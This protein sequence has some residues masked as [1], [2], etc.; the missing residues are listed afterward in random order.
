MPSQRRV[1]LGFHIGHDRSAALVMDGRVVAMVAEERLDRRKY[2]ASDTI[3]MK[4]VRYVLALAGVRAD[5]VTDIAFTHGG[6][7]VS[8]RIE[9]NWRKEILA[10]LDLP[11]RPVTMLGHHFAHACAAF[12]TSPS[13]EAAIAVADG[14][15]DI[16]DDEQCE[17]E[18]FYTADEEGITLVANRFQNNTIKYGTALA[19]ERF[20]YMPPSIRDCQISIGRKYQQVTQMLGFRFGQAGKTMGLA[21]YVSPTR[22]PRH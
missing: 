5:V 18:S 17:A 13:R 22:L 9:E 14:A 10:A 12:Y 1:A 21:P 4:A 15:G 16:P 19:V 11:E 2:S 6:C 20:D 3:P 8:A 7:P